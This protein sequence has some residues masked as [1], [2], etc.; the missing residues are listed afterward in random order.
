MPSRVTHVWGSGPD[1]VT[2]GVLIVR[3]LSS[4]WY[5]VDSSGRARV[6]C[7]T[8]YLTARQR[9]DDSCRTVCELSISR[10]RI[11]QTATS[12]PEVPS[13]LASTRP[14]V[15]ASTV[16]TAQILDTLALADTDAEPAPRSRACARK[17]FINNIWCTSEWF[18]HWRSIRCANR[19][20]AHALL[21]NTV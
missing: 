10:L 16:T 17:M 1:C 13:K 7:T 8:R 11:P 21:A 14:C 6:A 18:A 3:H 20:R 9:T 5:P 12:V 19:R 15:G 2:A 4:A